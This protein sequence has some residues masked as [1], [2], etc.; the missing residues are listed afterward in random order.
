[1][2]PSSQLTFITCTAVLA[3]TLS[4][5]SPSATSS[6]SSSFSPQTQRY[7]AAGANKIKH[8]VI[9][10]QE[11]RTIDNLFQGFPGAD[12]RSQGKNSRG[13]TIK[14]T[15]ASLKLKYIIN[16]SAAAM[17]DACDGSVKLPG[18]K[19]KMDG[20]DKE[21]SYGGPQNPEYVYVPHSESKPYW[22]MAN[23]WVLG[24]D[25]HTSQ[26]DESFASHQYIIA[27]QAAS[28]V[29]V[30][31]QGEWGCAGNG[32]VETLTQA[33]KYGA[34][35]KPCFDYTTL[36]DELDAAGLTWRFYASKIAQPMGGFWSGYQAIKHIRYGKDWAN[37][38]TPQKTILTD[39]P[40]GKLASVT[41]VTPTCETSDH[42]ACGGG[43]GP[44]WVT[45][46]VNAIGES[47]YWD[48]T[49]IFVFWDDWG[50]LYDHVPPPMVDYDGLGFRTPLLVISPY[51]KHHFVSKVQYEHGSILKFAEDIFGLPRMADSDTRATSVA[52][53]C[54]DFNQKPR[55]F[56]PIQAPQKAS[57]FL[58]RAADER[59]PDYE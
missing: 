29:D 8:V 28:S 7:A 42:S 57:F 9:I 25:F 23:E 15:P 58:T 10:V 5:C 32:Q 30:P 26:V 45:S 2:R 59:A 33:R 13:E 44:A 49:A 38:V 43:L 47:K 22:D 56:V 52:G 14:L 53:D 55:K 12:T 50:G 51:A 35:Q 4:A 17:F 3:S 19:C 20:F 37:V 6:Q 46:V 21:G 27:G 36:G 11:N 1:M 16:H 41:W 54:F 31:N 48:S 39:V 34:T 40:G 18:T 24:D